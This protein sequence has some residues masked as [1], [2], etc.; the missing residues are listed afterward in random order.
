MID[1]EAK[2]KEANRIIDRMQKEEAQ[3]RAILTADGPSDYQTP[4]SSL[5]KRV[6]TDLRNRNEKLTA[7]LSFKE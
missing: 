1:L 5:T 7:Q 4:L 3:T 6:I 2:F